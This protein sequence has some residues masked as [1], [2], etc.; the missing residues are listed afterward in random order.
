MCFG[1]YV[2]ARDSQYLE[3]FTGNVSEAA[4]KYTVHC[5]WNGHGHWITCFRVKLNRELFRKCSSVGEKR[6]EY[7]TIRDKESSIKYCERLCPLKWEEHL[8]SRL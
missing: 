3:N 5:R 2:T 1:E 8:C 6:A 7:T 4:F